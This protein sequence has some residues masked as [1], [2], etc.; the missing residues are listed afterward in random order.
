MIRDQSAEGND[1]TILEGY[2]MDDI[3]ADTLE[4]YRIMFNSWNPQHVWRR[5]SG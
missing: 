3:D 4:R 2:S 5:A 1:S